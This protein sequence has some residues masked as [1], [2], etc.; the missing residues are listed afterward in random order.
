MKSL[1]TQLRLILVNI[2]LTSIAW[3]SPSLRHT[4]EKA[5]ALLNQATLCFSIKVIVLYILD[6]P[7]FDENE[8]RNHGISCLIADQVP[9]PLK[10]GTNVLLF[11]FPAAGKIP[12]NIAT[13][14][15]FVSSLITMSLKETSKCIRPPGIEPGTS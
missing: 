10:D 3:S 13:V 5:F 12:S 7:G 2:E 4:L 1:L 14:F 15:N 11:L 8:I 6:T 9:R